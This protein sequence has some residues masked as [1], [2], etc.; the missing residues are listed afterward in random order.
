MQRVLD[1][2]KKNKIMMHVAMDQL[3]LEELEK[4]DLCIGTYEVGELTHI[5]KSIPQGEVILG[6]INS[7]ELPDYL[8][9]LPMIIDV[10]LF[11]VNKQ[12]Q[13]KNRITGC[14][15]TAVG[16]LKRGMTLYTYGSTTGKQH[17]I[18]NGACGIVRMT[19]DS[20]I[21]WSYM[22]CRPECA[23]SQCGDSREVLR[24]INGIARAV[25]FGGDAFEMGY[26]QPLEDVLDRASTLLGR[27][28]ALCIDQ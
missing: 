15:L 27:K 8:K 6:K 11:K 2:V 4:A 9:Q 18:V 17:G 16:P 22:I 13:G 7:K 20:P 26:I 1:E 5:S 23:F 28:V 21:V 12:R 10:A 14:Q 25:L 24:D 19:A 3:R